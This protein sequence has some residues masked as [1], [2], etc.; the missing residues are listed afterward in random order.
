MRVFKTVRL[1]HIGMRQGKEDL[2]ISSQRAGLCRGTNK[3]NWRNFRWRREKKSQKGTSSVG[4]V[5][6]CSKKGKNTCGK[7]QSQARYD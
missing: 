7:P 6:N 1:V 3:G 4:P 2:K 5:K